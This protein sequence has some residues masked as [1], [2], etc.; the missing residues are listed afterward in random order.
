MVRSA[1][2]RKTVEARAVN[3]RIRVAIPAAMSREEERRVVAQMV[4]RLERRRHAGQVDLEQRSAVLSARHGLPRPASICWVDNQAS[5]WGSCTPGERSVRLS[6][7][8]AGF[9]PWVVD[10]VIV[11]ELAHLVVPGHGPAFWDL[12]ARYPLAERARGYLLAKGG[13]EEE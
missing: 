3:G 10:Y 4:A 13:D 9:P 12:V 8:L 2:R 5:R 6:T 11:H 1:R 7:R